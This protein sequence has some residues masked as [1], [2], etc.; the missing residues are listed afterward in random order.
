MNEELEELILA[1]ESFS[2][3]RDKEAERALD[4]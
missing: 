2:A 3:S 1:Y 4:F